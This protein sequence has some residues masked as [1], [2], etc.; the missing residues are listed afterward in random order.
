ML[1][2]DNRLGDRGVTPDA[3][4]PVGTR[5]PF[6]RWVVRGAMVLFGL[7]FVGLLG[8][9][10]VGYRRFTL[11]IDFAIFSQAWTQIGTGHL[12]PMS[13]LHGV[14]FL[15][16]HF[17]LIM[18]PLA[19]LHPI[20][21]S[22]FVLLVIQDVALVGT[23]VV[24]FL[25]VV[26]MLRRSTLTT[27]WVAAVA[28]GAALLLLVDPGV[29]ATVVEDFHFEALSMFFVVFAAFD[30]WSGRTRRMWVWVVLCLLC[31]DVSG[32]Y[33]LALGL[34]GICLR[35]TRRQGV[36]LAA[37]GFGWVA[38]VSLLGLNAGTNISTAYAYLAD[39]SVLP[40]GAAGLWLVAQGLVLHPGRAVHVAVP[41]AG[42]AARYV[43][44]GGGVGVF[45]PWGF[46]MALVV[47]GTSILQSN[48]IFIG[49][50]FQN[51]VVVP[52]VL[53]GS[54]WLI[55]WSVQR[56]STPGRNAMAVAIAVLA[57]LIGLGS[58]AQRLPTAL[59]VNASHGFVPGPTAAALSQALARTPSDAEVVAPV[60]T[61]GRF[62]QRRYVYLLVDQPGVR[63]SPVPVRSGSVVVVVD[64]SIEPALLPPA[65]SSAIVGQ[66]EARGARVLVSSNGVT[67]VLW[68]PSPGV[69]SLPLP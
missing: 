64:P 41:R 56:A 63:S 6:E 1:P 51:V 17:E 59:E 15:K 55:V 25:W 36:A 47:L 35:D 13:T 52:F 69:T 40:S 24:A 23:E 20:V 5:P 19:L 28:G 29:Y 50:P 11:G 26:A 10:I 22:P 44:Y 68:H 43:M 27:S 53:F 3:A 30:L 14:P 16:N 66:L 18:W 38:L 45:T 62:G 12:D 42:A 32:I 21:H 57:L 8:L 37:V 2:E 54:A 4:T 7:Q 67:A 65:T 60:P 31:E 58:S 34:S 33:V 49:L 9:S 61:V 48:G 46:F 39:R